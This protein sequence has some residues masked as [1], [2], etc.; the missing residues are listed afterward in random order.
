[1]MD[2]PCS[3]MSTSSSSPTVRTP[4][5]ASSG[6]ISPHV[7]STATT[8]VS[9]STGHGTLRG[10]AFVDRSR[11]FICPPRQSSL[12]PHPPDRPRSCAWSAPAHKPERGRQPRYEGRWS[13]EMDYG[14][15]VTTELDGARPGRRPW[16]VLAEVGATEGANTAH[17][18]LVS[19]GLLEGDGLLSLLLGDLEPVT[20]GEDGGGETVQE[21]RPVGA[22]SVSGVSP[23]NHSGGIEGSGDTPDTE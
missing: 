7:V 17:H 1:M 21:V 23:L 4:G 14:S 2:A 6:C 18:G 9:P 5:A 13:C 15:T 16:E 3:T 20:G 10:F 19:C 8:S 22:G 11:R 12:E